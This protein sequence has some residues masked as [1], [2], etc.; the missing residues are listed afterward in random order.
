MQRQA[1]GWPARDVPQTGP[2]RESAL[3]REVGCRVV[4][5][6]QL[7]M[8]Q[9]RLSQSG[10]DD[11]VVIC[12]VSPDRARNHLNTSKTFGKFHTGAASSFLAKPPRHR[13]GVPLTP[14]GQRNACC[15]DLPHALEGGPFLGTERRRRGFDDVA[16]GLQSRDRLG[17]GVQTG[18]VHV[19]LGNHRL[20]QHADA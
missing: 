10:A 19:G 7:A 12:P 4:V 13:H 18:R 8:W 3:G 6:V 16:H 20:G 1:H 11:E 9:R 15:T 14:L 2:R 5:I 17:D